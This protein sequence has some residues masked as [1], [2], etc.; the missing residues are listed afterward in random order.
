MG[1]AN[2]PDQRKCSIYSTFMALSA[3]QD[4][5]EN[6]PDQDAII[7]WMF[8]NQAADEGFAF[9]TGA[10]GLVPI[11]A[12][13]IILLN[14]L[15]VS[16]PD[17][18]IQWLIDR[19]NP[20]GGFHAAPLLPFPDLLSTATALHALKTVNCSLDDIREPCINFINSVW[21]EYGF[22]GMTVDDTVDGEYTFYGL[23]ALG[24]MLNGR[25]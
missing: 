20:E 23:L 24:N 19:H 13:A 21:R 14:F 5:E 3:Y 10:K 7:E 12:G 25:E 4:L 18:S 22:C 15:N 2:Q 16:V 6:M 8:T 11:T 1:F 17:E 9:K